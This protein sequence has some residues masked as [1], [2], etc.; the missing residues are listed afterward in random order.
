MRVVEGNLDHSL[1]RCLEQEGLGS[2]A[3][4]GPTWV[5]FEEIVI[6]RSQ[7]N[8]QS[9]WRAYSP[10]CGDTGRLEFVGRG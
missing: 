3:V 6:D 5:S 2:T 9:C 7:P 1:S 4:G 8:P 10:Q